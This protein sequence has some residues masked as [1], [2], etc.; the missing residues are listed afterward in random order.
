MVPQFSHVLCC[1]CSFSVDLKAE[2]ASF[3]SSKTPEGQ[4]LTS[5]TAGEAEMRTLCYVIA[6][7]AMIA[8]AAGM[9]NAEDPANAQPHIQAAS[10]TASR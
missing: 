3:F 7:T 9:G 1:S 4:K 10:V 8:L 6:A 5:I 2:H